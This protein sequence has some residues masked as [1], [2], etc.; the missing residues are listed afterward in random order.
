MPQSSVDS[1]TLIAFSDYRSALP[2]SLSEQKTKNILLILAHSTSRLV[3]L[4]PGAQHP[5]VLKC[6]CPY[7]EISLAIL[8]IV[9]I[10]TISTVSPYVQQKNGT[11]VNN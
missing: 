4:T 7:F 2:F 1:Q 10:K 5:S 11:Q 9:I 6:P 8:I 3:L